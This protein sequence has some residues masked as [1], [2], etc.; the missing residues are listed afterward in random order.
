MVAQWISVFAS[1]SQP[2]H[3]VR[4]FLLGEVPE[5]F[6]Y[7]TDENTESF[8]ENARMHEDHARVGSHLLAEA[9]DQPVPSWEEIFRAQ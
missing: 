5:R 8:V 9:S 3:A 1:R 6:P 4:P 2:F 7:P